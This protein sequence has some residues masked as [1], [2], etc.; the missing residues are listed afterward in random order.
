MSYEDDVLA[1]LY[2]DPGPQF[3][4]KLTQPTIGARPGVVP[5][6]A[7]QGFADRLMGSGRRLA[8]NPVVQG[9]LMMPAGPLA[10]LVGPGI[11]AALGRRDPVSFSRP[12]AQGTTLER[13]DMRP[14]E[15]GATA[16][17]DFTAAPTLDPRYQ[18]RKPGMLSGPGGM[19]GG[20]NGLKAAW[21]ASRQKLLDDYDTDKSLQYTQGAN[22]AD[23]V[24][25]RARLA[26][27]EA[28]IKQRHAELQ[29]QAD[30]DAATKHEAFLARNQQLAD[31]ISEKKTSVEQVVGDAFGDIGM[32]VGS[33]LLARSGNLDQAFAQYNK[34]L[35]RAVQAQQQEI[36]NKKVRLSARQS[37]FGQMMQE[38]G[39]RR[40]A[41]LATRNL[42]L[43]ATKQKLQAD[44]DRLGI[45][46]IKTNAEMA[47]NKVQH[48]QDGLNE[49]MQREGYQT[50]L[51]NA[52]AAA[53]AAAAAE[54]K[55]YKRAQAE[56]EYMLKVGE[57][58]LKAAE[59]DSKQGQQQKKDDEAAL[60]TAAERMGKD[61][62]VKNKD[63]VDSLSRKL[64]PI[65]PG[66]EPE[67]VP[68]VGR[69][70]D[71]R[72]GLKPFQ[73]EGGKYDA[74]NPAGTVGKA[75]ANK[76][77]G[78]DDNERIARME[79]EQLKLLYQTKV[80]GSGGSDQQMVAIDKAFR[81]ANTP[82][83]QRRAV[84]MAQEDQARREALA[85]VNLT[86]SQKAEFARRLA[87]D[88]G[89]AE[90]PNSVRSK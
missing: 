39:D 21:D 85:T 66:E 53:A 77:L 83:E 49:T 23:E 48:E 28:A 20:G 67:G 44:A 78:L 43:E 2:A 51:A 60:S 52:R 76:L 19:G 70:N 13:V 88:K 74:L 36:E 71:L 54:E 72:A 63:L 14:I 4:A 29:Q 34:R 32:V 89:A 33:M 22:R 1:G 17:T 45:P 62:V 8:S 37:V 59:V 56:R 81:G 9:G 5:V 30:V 11:G 69:V 64:K 86:E 7:S 15:P 35:D 24:A 68:G 10:P 79:F 25:G 46:S 6:E 41:S 31:E 90:M 55:A 82:A 12:P 58:K 3:E 73:G 18:L 16:D 47:V 84:L 40:L 27:E 50:Y 42:M 26:T 38:T 65:T 87:R 80:T 75:F 61:D 57:L